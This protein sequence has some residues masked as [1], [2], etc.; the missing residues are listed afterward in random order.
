MTGGYQEDKQRALSSLS[1]PDNVDK[2]NFLTIMDK[3]KEHFDLDSD[4]LE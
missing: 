4:Q 2:A 3:L 1:S